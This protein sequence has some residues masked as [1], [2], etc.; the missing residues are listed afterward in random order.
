[1]V[2]PL[3]SGG[4]GGSNQPE[5]P[6]PA[7]VKESHSYWWW[8]LFLAFVSTAVIEVVGGDTF[9]M[10]FTLI[11]AAI[12]Y[13]MVS[14][15]CANMSMYCLL[16]F[17]LISGFEA[18]FALLTL[19]SELGGRSSTSTIISGNDG[20][21]TT[22][23]TTV[24][25]HPFFDG[26]QGWKYNLQSVAMILLPVI[27]LLGAILSWYS[28]KAFPTPLFGDFD[29]EESVGRG[30]FGGSMR[31]PARG[32]GGTQAANSARREEQSRAPRL[33]E[34]EGQRLGS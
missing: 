16:V 22:Y 25:T 32:Y 23:T 19:L 28:F 10:L 20:S 30:G 6:A 11:M 18:L 5:A 3:G 15:S 1:M 7:V 17:G 27:M 2:I 26:S 12:I 14:N 21:T 31:G 8:A 29:E 33:F 9:G 24:S 34:G 13:Y 4:F